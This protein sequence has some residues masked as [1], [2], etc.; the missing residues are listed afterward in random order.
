MPDT[1]SSW[2]S[3][4]EPDDQPVLKQQH[5]HAQQQLQHA[6]APPEVA[7]CSHDHQAPSSDQ[8]VDTHLQYTSRLHQ[9]PQPS[10]SSASQAVATQLNHSMVSTGVPHNVMQ[11]QIARQHTDERGLFN[12]AA[13]MVYILA[14]ELGLNPEQLSEEKRWELM[15]PAM[16]AVS[17][18]LNHR[19]NQEHHRCCD[20]FQTAM[21]LPHCSLLGI[22]L[23]GNPSHFLKLKLSQNSVGMLHATWLAELQCCC[24]LVLH[25]LHA[26]HCPVFSTMCASP[27]LCLAV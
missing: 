25:C 12:N 2:G 8:H 1:A 7:S 13:R 18:Q 19:N 17:L 26:V 24:Y 20:H 10:S 5:Q 27:M 16:N 4:S 22:H 15:I 11:P 14:Q 9:Q 3:A 23:H 21:H 6:A